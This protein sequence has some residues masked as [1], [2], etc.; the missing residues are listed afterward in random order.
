MK[1]VPPDL[2]VE[3]RTAAAGADGVL[4]APT[5]AIG[6]SERRQAR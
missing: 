5:L 1:L 6:Q 2:M 4:L 3:F